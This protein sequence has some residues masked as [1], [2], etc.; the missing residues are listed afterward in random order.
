MQNFFQ[1][2]TDYEA[3]EILGQCLIARNYDKENYKVYNLR[4]SSE[5]ILPSNERIH[6]WKHFEAFPV[7]D[8]FIINLIFGNKKCCII[9][10]S[11]KLIIDNS[12]NA[13]FDKI[14]VENDIIKAEKKQS[15]FFFNSAG[16]LLLV[17]KLN[18]NKNIV[19]LLDTSNNVLIKNILRASFV[20]THCSNFS[21]LNI[22]TTEGENFCYHFA[23]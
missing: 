2:D 3:F 17:A 1:L 14:S 7:E 15:A 18:K 22:T 10:N 6:T 21:G 13:I 20:H 19:E 16:E 11:G 5:I 12:Q 9:A 4:D 8:D 23:K